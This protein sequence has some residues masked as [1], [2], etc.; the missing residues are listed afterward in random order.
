MDY[1]KLNKQL[2]TMMDESE[3]PTERE[4]IRLLRKVVG[5]MNGIEGCL[6]QA[7][8]LLERIIDEA[9]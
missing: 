3:T 4:L 9:G 5:H 1:D 6:E 2:N 7:D 8:K